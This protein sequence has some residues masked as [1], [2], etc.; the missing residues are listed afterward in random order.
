MCIFDNTP[1]P[2]YEEQLPH[3]PDLMTEVPVHLQSNA[4]LLARDSLINNVFN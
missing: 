4:G 3:E 1:L 2:G